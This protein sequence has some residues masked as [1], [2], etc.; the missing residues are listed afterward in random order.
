MD[1]ETREQIAR[2]DNRTD[3][4]LQGLGHVEGRLDQLTLS[5][6]DNFA[7][8]QR[9]IEERFGMLMDAVSDHVRRGH[10]E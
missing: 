1:D 8:L 6:N 4:V 7:R 2:L 10:P 5:I 9:Q 3:A